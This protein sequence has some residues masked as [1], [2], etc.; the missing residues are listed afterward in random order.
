MDTAQLRLH[1]KRLSDK[2]IHS[3]IINQ[4]LSLDNQSLIKYIND[5]NS[6]FYRSIS[7]VECT[8]KS[9]FDFVAIS[10]VAIKL[11]NVLEKTDLIKRFILVFNKLFSFLLRIAGAQRT[12]N[13]NFEM[14]EMTTMI[15]LKMTDQ[16]KV[17]YWQNQPF[18]QVMISALRGYFVNNSKKQNETRKD[19]EVLCLLRPTVLREVF[20]VE[21]RV[22]DVEWM[23]GLLEECFDIPALYVV[24]EYQE[25]L[26]DLKSRS[27]DEDQFMQMIKQEFFEVMELDEAEMSAE[28]MPKIIV[29]LA[30]KVQNN[31]Q[32]FT[33]RGEKKIKDPNSAAYLLVQRL[34]PFTQKYNNAEA[35]KA[36]FKSDWTKTILPRFLS[37]LSTRVTISD[38]Q[39]ERLSHFFT[40]IQNSFTNKDTTQENNGGASNKN[41]EQGNKINNDEIKGDENQGNETETQSK[42]RDI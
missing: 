7:I 12:K 16:Q 32:G 1:L 40:V 25:I 14:W 23:A 31:K 5:I 39:K 24:H 22:R 6:E 15:V 41:E 28:Q 20:G 2:T 27:I 3:Q 35:I 30:Q 10:R 37:Y 34:L 4:W 19:I 21:E 18:D 9:H 11:E 42:G 8:M 38:S 33:Q 17:Q 26:S 13:A 29:G 36:K